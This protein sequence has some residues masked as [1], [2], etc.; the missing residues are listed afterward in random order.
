MKGDPMKANSHVPG[1]VVNGFPFV[2]LIPSDLPTHL[3]L[4]RGLHQ[5]IVRERNQ[6]VERGVEPTWA[7]FIRL[8]ISAVVCYCL[9]VWKRELTTIEK[10]I[11]PEVLIP[12]A[13]SLLVLVATALMC[14][15]IKMDPGVQP[16]KSEEHQQMESEYYNKNRKGPTPVIRPIVYYGH[17]SM[18]NYCFDCKHFK[19]P[20]TIHCKYCDR[21][22]VRHDHH[23]NILGT[24]VGIRN[25]AFYFYFLIFSA[26]FYIYIFS[27]SV[28]ILV[29]GLR[30]KEAVKAFQSVSILWILP[31]TVVVLLISN[32]GHILVF[33]FIYF[34]ITAHDKTA[35][36]LFFV[37]ETQG[38]HYK[39]YKV[40][41]ALRG[42]R[43]RSCC[44]GLLNVLN[45]LRVYLCSPVPPSLLD[46]D[47]Y[48][49]VCDLDEV[50]TWDK[51]KQSEATGPKKSKSVGQLPD[52][53]EDEEFKLMDTRKISCC[54][55]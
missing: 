1:Y 7:L 54:Y 27:F 44:K 29:K 12:F 3:R 18:G 34:Y 33:P 2:I 23:C 8:L 22:V 4:I 45:N 5:L 46:E 41:K 53:K 14:A 30:E 42:E 40:M 31:L 32:L 49:V 9:C 28:G 35:H 48:F 6:V 55:F 11:F 15:T 13:A 21:C 43:K 51:L 26:L 24:C 20:R 10:W 17:R 37:I 36:E 16:K 39:C 52:Y 19:H 47:N 50:L 25:F 38:R